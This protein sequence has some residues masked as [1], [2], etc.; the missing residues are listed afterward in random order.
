MTEPVPAEPPIDNEGGVKEDSLRGALRRAVA[1]DPVSLDFIVQTLLD[2][3][4]P[5]VNVRIMDQLCPKCSCPH[6]RYV[7]VPRYKEAVDLA[8]KLM[9]QVEG[10]PGVAG[11]EEAG[12]IVRRVVVGLDE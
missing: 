9:D 4:K 6:T 2:A 7:L 12:V 3:C 1:D 10:R 8:I 5:Q 11:V